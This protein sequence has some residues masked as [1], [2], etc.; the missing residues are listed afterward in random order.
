MDDTLKKALNVVG[1]CL[2]D[3]QPDTMHCMLCHRVVL[4]QT[5]SECEACAD[6]GVYVG[7]G[8]DRIDGQG[9]FVVVKGLPTPTQV[10]QGLN[11]NSTLDA[12][13][14]GWMDGLVDSS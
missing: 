1:L 6:T 9:M 14:E 3:N 11:Q 2:L 4:R 5:V 12:A 10:G 8:L 7:G 13:S